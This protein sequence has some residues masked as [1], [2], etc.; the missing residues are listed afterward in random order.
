MTQIPLLQEWYFAKK[1]EISIFV[2]ARKSVQMQAYFTN[3]NYAIAL[4]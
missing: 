2:V 3:I 1:T 4:R